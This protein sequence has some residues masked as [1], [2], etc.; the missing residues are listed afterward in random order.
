[1]RNWQPC[2]PIG[3]PGNATPTKATAFFIR[4]V[5]LALKY[6]NLIPCKRSEMYAHLVLS[7]RIEELV[8]VYQL[9]YP[10]IVRLSVAINKITRGRGS[11]CRVHR[12]MQVISLLL[13]LE[14]L[15]IGT[16]QQRCL[17]LSCLLLSQFLMPRIS[18]KCPS[19]VM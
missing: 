13:W 3:T 7:S 8:V 4:K 12:Y 9:P 10:V 14:K 16:K 1:M 19:S 6:C 11:F 15:R 5:T 17:L 2:H 18:S